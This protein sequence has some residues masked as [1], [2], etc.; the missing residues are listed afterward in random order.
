MR[1]ALLPLLALIPL[2]VACSQPIELADWGIDV[3]QG[4][5]VREA[6]PIPLEERS[7]DIVRLVDD[8][9]IGGPDTPGEALLFRPIGI[10]AADDGRMF[11]ADYGRH[12]VVSFDADGGYLG[13]FGGE[14]QGPAEFGSMR[15]IAIAGER[16]AVEDAGNSRLSVW[17]VEGEHV[18]DYPLASRRTLLQMEG[19]GND[20]FVSTFIGNNDQGERR[21]IVAEYALDG[22]LRRRFFDIPMPPPLVIREGGGVTYSTDDL[23]K[24]MIGNLDNPKIIEATADDVVYLSP[25]HEYQVVAEDPGGGIRWALRVAWPRPPR[26]LSER[27]RDVD[28]AVRVGDRSASVDDFDFPPADALEF[29]RTDGAGRLYVFP[30]MPTEDD[31]PAPARMVDVYET[32]GEL[33]AAG[34]VDHIWS[35]ARGDYVYGLR[36]NAQGERV[37]VRYRLTVNKR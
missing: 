9:V 35:F 26:S 22:G 10:V 19:I 27:Q 29:L 11:V 36:T 15:G 13:S 6:A 31:E 12:E 8:L 33:L 34:L 24:A 17:T 4:T 1:R 23:V 2:T 28:N 32:N 14:G 16:I 30:T 21:L 37:A 7:R 25:A 3:P 18:R 5:P 20:G